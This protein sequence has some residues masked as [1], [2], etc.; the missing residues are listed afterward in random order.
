MLQWEVGLLFWFVG[1]KISLDGKR[2]APT[3][4]WKDTQ[5]PSSPLDN[6]FDS[7]L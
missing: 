1:L 3:W 5:A 4:N 7:S 6:V 2:G